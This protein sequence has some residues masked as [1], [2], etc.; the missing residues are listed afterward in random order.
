L[1]YGRLAGLG[2]QPGKYSGHPGGCRPRAKRP[3]R[4]V[5]GVR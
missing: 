4:D 3:P 5:G 1:S 2:D